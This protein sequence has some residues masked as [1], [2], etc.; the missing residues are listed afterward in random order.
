M[1]K[2]IVFL[3]LLSVYGHCA[4]ILALV[5]TLDRNDTTGFVSMVTTPQDANA[6]RPDNNKTILM[7]ASWV[8]NYQAV[9]W[10][11]SHGADVNATD[12]S[13]AT[14]L[15]LAIWKR[16]TAIALYLLEQGASPLAMSKEGMTP[17]DIALFQNN[18]HVIHAIQR[19]KPRLKSIF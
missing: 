6:K 17:S 1:K 16:H 7:Y 2:G 10:L 8:G 19:R 18:T 13:N 9:E 11:V 4:D 15:H 14:A 3:L 12:A 5:G